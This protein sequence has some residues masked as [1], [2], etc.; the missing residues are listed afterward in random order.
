MQWAPAEEFGGTASV[1]PDTRARAHT[2]RDRETERQSAIQSDAQVPV[3]SS[4]MDC[5]LQRTEHTPVRRRVAFAPGETVREIPAAEIPAA[6][7]AATVAPALATAPSC[8]K[9]FEAV[10]IAVRP[11]PFSRRGQLWRPHARSYCPHCGLGRLWYRDAHGHAATSQRPEGALGAA[12]R[13]DVPSA[14]ELRHAFEFY[15]AKS[16][17]VCPLRLLDEKLLEAVLAWLCGRRGS[18]QVRMEYQAG[19]GARAVRALVASCR[20]G[21]ELVTAM[22]WV[23]GVHVDL[24]PHQVAAL[25][26]CCALEARRHSGRVCG[27]V[28]C[29]EA[30]LG[31][32]ITAL[33]LMCRMRDP[34]VPRVP[35]GTTLQGES[36]R[37]FYTLEPRQLNELKLLPRDRRRVLMSKQYDPVSGGLR[38]PGQ[39]L[40]SKR[41]IFNP[42]YG[43]EAGY[44]SAGSFTRSRGTQI[45]EPVCTC[46]L[47]IV[48]EELESQWQRE[49][50]EKSNLR[51]RIVLR[52]DDV[53][54][55]RRQAEAT[56]SQFP[57]NITH[58]FP[59]QEEVQR[60]DVV[61][62]TMERM[63][64]RAGKRDGVS[65]NDGMRNMSDGLA[66]VHWARIIIDEGHELG[67]KGLSELAQVLGATLAS[68]T[69]VLSA[70][71][72][73]AGSGH[74]K[75]V[76][77]RAMTDFLQPGAAGK[78]MIVR[79]PK[80]CIALPTL[81]CQVEWLDF[82]TARQER[83]DR[84]PGG[85]K[86]YD[87]AVYRSQMCASCRSMPVEHRLVGRF[88]WS[89]S[90]DTQRKVEERNNTIPEWMRLTEE[91][92]LTATTKKAEYVA[93]ALDRKHIKLPA[94][95]R[96]G[97]GHSPRNPKAQ[98][99]Q[100]AE[101]G[102]AWAGG[103]SAG[104]TLVYSLYNSELYIAKTTLQRVGGWTDA[105]SPY[106][107]DFE[108]L[109]PHL[110]H[111]ALQLGYTP[112]SWPNWPVRMQSLSV[113][114]GLDLPRYA[115]IRL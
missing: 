95:S 91:L 96:S 59:T 7:I 41:K 3:P 77:S 88:A 104:K 61:V 106:K 2:Q 49:L 40:R 24:F 97:D 32:T 50:K 92:L 26:R 18:R 21:R 8:E 70:T 6:G 86:Q 75:Q 4:S 35:I 114:S 64:S 98:Q 63:G 25:N 66:S 30:G 44:T 42:D 45:V 113:I 39:P 73:R 56:F 43:L 82:D 15:A 80:E 19:V 48:P 22:R 46:S 5:E 71:P 55:L 108:Q 65:Q 36:P 54:I 29:D 33:A 17:A 111:D 94:A 110:Q 76:D 93:Q 11:L 31:K 58:D 83:L 10:P 53:K 57:D 101:E 60:L 9:L 51:H 13:C 69:W 20:R 67:G 28:L 74:F 81:N 12:C 84:C 23:P 72:N 99:L 89:S 90:A 68:A 102:A 38:G 107:D 78:E 37:R 27:G 47:L 109:E 115:N 103:T 14:D 87:S 105:A 1:A 100:L 79:T 112:E 52:P 62:T 16:N 34:A 85:C